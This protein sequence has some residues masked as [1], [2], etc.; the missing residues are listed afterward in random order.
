MQLAINPELKN[1]IPP[2]TFD[3]YATLEQSILSEGCREPLI[4]WEGAIV[5]GHNRYE[6]CN[7]YNIEFK[8]QDKS[9]E[10][11]DDAKIWMIDNQKGRRNLTDGWKYELAQTKKKILAKKGKENISEAQ[12][13]RHGI[14]LSVFD[15]VRNHNTRKAIADDLNWSTGKTAQADYVWSKADKDPEVAEIKKKAMSGDITINKAYEIIKKTEKKKALE[16]KKQEYESRVEEVATQRV[17]SFVDILNTDKTFRIFYADPPWKYDL[18]QTSPNLGGAIKHYNS[19]TIE[20]LCALPIKKISQKNATLFLWITSPKLNHFLEIMD[21]WGFTYK[22]SFVWDKVKHNM[23]HYNSIRH[24][25]LLI[26]GKGKSAPDIQKLF[27]SVQSI[28]RSDTHSQKPIE[29]MNIID[30]LYIYGER[31]ELFARKAQKPI[32]FHWGNEV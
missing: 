18:E 13:E 26:G 7:R 27:D 11:L 10:S 1:I 15:K 9:F 30:E 3:E 5:D 21:A 14:T 24:E 32:W 20:E 6:I 31:I 17:E 8:T 28:E 23:G 22:T 4:V 16:S 12:K 25:F 19:M 2:L 29:F